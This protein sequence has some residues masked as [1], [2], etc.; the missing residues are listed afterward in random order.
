MNRRAFG[1]AG[2]DAACAYLVRRGY[3]IL[4]RNFRRRCGEVD[5]IARKRGVLAFVEVKRR[6][7]LGFGRPAEAVD[8]KKQRHIV[9]TALLY[10]MENGMEDA[11]VRFDIIEILPARVHHI[12]NAFDATGIF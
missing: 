3:E 8:A 7:G 9:Q 6:S 2:E 5:V 11:Q 10:L 4:E 1:N 12:E